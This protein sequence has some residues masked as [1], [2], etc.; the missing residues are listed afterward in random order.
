MTSRYK[1]V[2][3][4]GVGILTFLVLLYLGL[5]LYISLNHHVLKNKLSSKI[6]ERTRGEVIM[7]SIS[8]A[9]FKTFPFISVEINH[10]T[11]RDSA[12]NLHKIDLLKVNIEGAERLVIE[13]MGDVLP[14]I[15][16][17]AISCHDFRYK[18]EGGNEFFKTKKI[19]TDFLMENGFTIQ[20]LKSGLE[21]RDDWIFGKNSLAI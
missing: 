20:T 11:L 16:N 17:V 21:H 13:T 10:L 6:Q 14:I 1:K 15:R 18:H 3:L 19:V 8:P 2:A 5:A 7:G 9:F 12:Y 4:L